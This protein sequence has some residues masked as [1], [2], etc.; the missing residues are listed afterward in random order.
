MTEL[1]QA[2]NDFGIEQ[3]MN[4]DM[5]SAG[6]QELLNDLLS[7]ETAT[8][9]PEDVISLAEAAEKEKAEKA[10][11]DK[12]VAD[13]AAAKVAEG[14]PPEKAKSPEELTNYLLGGDEDETEDEK[15]ARITAEEEASAAGKTPESTDDEGGIAFDALS[16]ELFTLGVFNKNEGE[17]EVDITDA[18]GFL[19]RFTAEKQKG[20]NEMVQNFL[21]QFGQEHQDAFQAIYVDGADPREYFTK[22][23]SI[24]DFKSM[25]LTVEKNQEEVIRKTL[26]TQ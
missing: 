4:V 18:E 3:T 6:S 19:D 15:A 20:A 1:E 24:S 8:G 7:P 25:D 21:G 23:A 12:V 13:E 26:N 9:S 10:A 17:G 16:N 14:V 11:A 5:G 22:Q 2:P